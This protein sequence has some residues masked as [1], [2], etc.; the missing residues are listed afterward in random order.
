[1]MR[2]GR[3]IEI[4]G[5]VQG[6]GLRP[7]VYRLAT[8]EGLS[9]RVRNDEAGVTIEAFGSADALEVFTRRLQA[10]APVAAAIETLSAYEIPSEP[11]ESFSISLSH[12]AAVDRR[13]SI[14]PDLATCPVC[15]SEVFDPTDR[16]YRYPFTN[17]TECGPRFT[18]A[19]DVPYD[20]RTTTMAP[21]TMCADCQR[22][23]EEVQNRRFHA[24]PNA[25]PACGPRVQLLGHDGEPLEAE[26]P[27]DLAA[28]ALANGL[29]VAVKGLGGFH[30]ACDA[31]A[32]DAVRRL[33][34]RKRRDEKP[35]AVM[36]RDVGEAELLATIGEQER[37]LLASA[38]RPIVL[39]R[40]SAS[41][42]VA[43][44]VAPGSP[45]IGLMLAYTPLHHL[46]LHDA[47]RP[48]VMTSANLSDEPLAYCNDEAIRRL[49]TIADIFLV[50]DR[51]IE[52]RCDDSVARVVRDRPMLLRRSRG[53]VPRPVTV[54]TRFPRPVLACGALLKNTFCIGVND[55]AYL[56]PHIGDLENL[57]TY[58]SFEQNIA[59][60]ERILRVTP[61]VIAHDLHPE[62]MST[63]YAHAHP[64]ET[65]IAVQHHHAH[66]AS[67]MAEHGLEGPVI[68]VAYDGTGCGTDGTAWGGEILIARYDGYERVATFRPVPLAG[69]DAAI[70]NPWRIAL[71]LVD[72]AFEGE[73]DL[74]P[75]PVFSTLSPDD[76]RVARRM[77]ATRFRS[78][79]ARGVG[80]YFDA[81]GA[82]VL[83]RPYARYEGQVALAW[84]VVADSAEEGRYYFDFDRG[85]TPWT[86]DLR[87]MVRQIVRDMA[88]DVGASIISARFH[89]TL[90]AATSAMVRPVA[91]QYGALPVVLTGGCFQNDRLVERVVR[92]L[93]DDFT[94]HLHERVP[95]G[96]GGIALGQAVVAGA[97]VRRFG[98]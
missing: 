17:C 76:V 3:R 2:V 9:G 42:N 54:A 74:D 95:P 89:N 53:Y 36:V 58:E 43:V 38:E 93:G 50:H 35:F 68:G 15:L 45:L 44:D 21:F 41:C 87:P 13:L 40:R 98:T 51:A 22:E 18:I 23:F 29:I 10:S 34:V 70:R 73:V 78:P 90:G 31:T 5:V 85:Q 46:L 79:L 14:P 1:M 56:G 66:V 62:Y 33:R 27:I 61:E 92:E 55:S 47:Q 32:S 7:W 84:N 71:A 16:R 97:I 65:K 30:L 88:N 20:R 81:I 4:R 82:L 69:A 26:D 59:C 72:D 37:R 63:K 11:L 94:V 49:C 24:Q 25:C 8:E 57:E 12:D 67:A 6:V 39:L 60:A 80:R 64:V 91:A 96:D 52:T 77:I 86:L 83:G 48:L 75:F 28:G 19:H